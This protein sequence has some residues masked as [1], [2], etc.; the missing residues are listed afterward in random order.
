ME[1]ITGA[2]EG[3]VS[4]PCKE[5]AKNI[6]V[7]DTTH[8]TDRGRPTAGLSTRSHG[9]RSGY[10]GIRGIIDGVL[11]V[12]VFTCCVGGRRDDVILVAQIY[13]SSNAMTPEVTH[14]NDIPIHSS[15]GRSVDHSLTGRSLCGISSLHL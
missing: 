11:I 8:I 14:V 7:F 15:G 9:L 3:G 12:S 4:G 13:V 2:V 10:K 5:S 6:L 1:I